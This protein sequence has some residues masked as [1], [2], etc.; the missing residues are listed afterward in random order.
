MSNSGTVTSCFAVLRSMPNS[1]FFEG[2]SSLG[3]CL[4]FVGLASGGSGDVARVDG[5]ELIS[6]SIRIE[7]RR[8]WPGRAKTDGRVMVGRGPR[9]S[10]FPALRDSVVGRSNDHDVTR[11][12][13]S[14]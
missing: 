14:A 1:D 9:T 13:A 10:A 11:Y 4:S 6:M 2:P 12:S 7:E 5:S 3:N 8:V